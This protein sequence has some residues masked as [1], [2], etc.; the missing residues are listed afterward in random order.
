[1]RPLAALLAGVLALPA[2]AQE[3]TIERATIPWSELERLMS[4]EGGSAPKREPAAKAPLGFAISAARVTGRVGLASADLE[5]NLDVEV[6]R[7]GWTVVPL[8]EAG[9]ALSSAQVAGPPG[10]RG[11]LVRDPASVSLVTEGVGRYQLQVH[12]QVPLEATREGRR[13]SWAPAGLAGGRAELEVS[14]SPKPLGR[15]RWSSTHGASGTHLTGALGAAGL[16]LVLVPRPQEDVDAEAEAAVADRPELEAVSVVSLGGRGVTRLVVMARPDSSGQFQLELPKGASLWKGY[17]A[18]KA[19]APSTG[20]ALRLPLAGPTLVEVAYT[21][22]APPLGIRGR[23]RVELP[24]FPHPVRTAR[25]D[26]WMPDGL[27]YRET[28]SSLTPSA[29]CGRATLR[30]RTPLEPQGRCTGFARPVL[31][32]GRA[33]VEGTYEQPL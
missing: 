6:L 29:T 26:L 28:Q 10:K 31:E 32:P 20:E 15:T 17:A 5:L 9:F 2:L 33:Y 27:A 11:L 12:A 3:V 8:F 14:G 13:L 24:R 16:D 19:L 7:D 23:Y 18:G 30:S 4:R 22:E 21:F 1:M 25:W